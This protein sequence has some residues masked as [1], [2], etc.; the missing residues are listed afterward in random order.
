MAVITSS[1][2]GDFSNA[3]IWVGGVVPV[4]NDSFIIANSHIVTYNVATP[5]TTGFDDSD[6]YGTL[7]HQANANTVLRMNGRLRIRT[8][9][10]YYMCDGSTLQFRG[11]ASASHIVYLL[12]ESNASFIADGSDGMPSTTL[13]QEYGQTNTFIQVANGASFRPGE[14]IAVMNNSFSVPTLGTSSDVPAESLRDEGFWIHDVQ[15]N[16][17]FI[18]QFVGPENSTVTSYTNNV[19]TVANSKVWRVGQKIIFGTGANRNIKNIIDINYTANTLTVNGP[20]L[21]NDS[22]YRAGAWTSLIANATFTTNIDAPDGSTD[23]VR[24]TQSNTGTAILRVAIPTVTTNGTDTYVLSFWARF[25]SGTKTT[26]PCDFADTNPS[27]DYSATLVAN[28]WRRVV[29]TGIPAA[30]SRTFIDLVSNSTTN[31]VVDFWGLQL[32]V[33]NTVTNNIASEYIPTNGTVRS[34]RGTVTGNTIYETGSDKIHAKS[35]KVRKIATA[36]TVASNSAQTTITVANVSSFLANDEIWIEAKSEAA[37][38]FDSRWDAYPRDT[39]FVH[40]VSSISANTITLTSAIG[41]NVA[42]NSL[43]TRMTRRIVVEPVAANSS[44]YGFYTETFTSNWTRRLIMKDIQFR[45]VGSSQGTAE[46]GVYLNL[47]YFSTSNVTNTGVTMVNQVPTWGSG[48]WIEGVTT[49]GSN[50][51]RDLG[52]FFNYIRMGQTRASVAVGR[53]NSGIA[54]WYIDGAAVYNSISAG[55]DTWGFR[56]EGYGYSGEFAYNY[57]SRNDRA[58][59]LA[60]YD[61]NMGTHHIIADAHNN[62]MSLSSF[63]G[64]IY[65]MKVTGARHGINVERGHAI[66]YYSQYKSL[67]GIGNSYDPLNPGS[68]VRNWYHTQLDRTSLGTAHTLVE[69]IED[70]F[71]IDKHRQFAYVTERYWDVNENAWRVIHIL[72]GED[73]GAGW[74]GW[75]WVPARST[76]RASCQIKLAPNFGTNYPVFEARAA[77]SGA[78]VNRVGNLN[79]SG[80]TNFRSWYGGGQVSN[81]YTA[82]ASTQYE[83]RQVTLTPVNFPRIVVV[84][85]YMNNR[86]QSRGFWMRDVNLYLDNQYVLPT[87]KTP[88]YDG[89]TSNFGVQ[90]NFDTRKIRLGGGR[91]K[92]T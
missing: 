16:T 81:T 11:A 73:A 89:G 43:V 63:I 55:G 42:A 10:C 18:R 9:G 40:R 57:S 61:G 59:R 33:A 80:D 46:S 35:D 14:W 27:G 24:W 17:L 79:I 36:T 68:Y 72:D 82:L 51:T 50:S 2:S 75:I 83:E 29:F 32:E 67:S 69:F 5:V 70:D 45:Y 34:I 37:N 6:I 39:P 4:D 49:I 90:S 48:P 7:R 78:F 8:N 3:Q 77:Q 19:I 41:Y 60:S 71:E 87:Y 44:Y 53:F 92:G 1:T 84:G 74:F 30:G 88:H 12:N 91:I 21:A 38:N 52:G 25:I 15:A 20:N 26:L 58:F 65:K 13:S 56:C 23:A 64:A 85:V 28:E 31:N 76:L 47:G 54:T 62:E 22:V 66:L 86:N